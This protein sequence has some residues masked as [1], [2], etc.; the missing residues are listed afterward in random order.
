MQNIFLEVSTKVIAN[1][2]PAR[3]LPPGV[4]QSPPDHD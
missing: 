4:A 2:S 1:Y 3:K